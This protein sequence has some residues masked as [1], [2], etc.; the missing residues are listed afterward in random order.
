MY[1]GR[2][3][4]GY[5]GCLSTILPVI[6]IKRHLKEKLATYVLPCGFIFSSVGILV[7]FAVCIP[8]NIVYWRLL[9]LVPVL[10]MACIGFII[11]HRYPEESLG[12]PTVDS[13]SK[14]VEACELKTV[15]NESFV[16]AIDLEEN[17]IVIP[18]REVQFV[19]LFTCEYRN[20]VKLALLLTMGG[21]LSGVSFIV[22]YSSDIF[23]KLNISNPELFTFLLGFS[24]FAG[25]VV[26]VTY[27]SR[28][29]KR[30]IILAGIIG[31]ALALLTCVL[32]FMIESSFLVLLGFNGFMFAFAISLGGELGPYL[33]DFIP[34]CGLAMVGLPN[35]ILSCLI[36][37]F[38]IK[39]MSALG[40]IVTFTLLALI[41]S[42]IAIFF[43]RGS[44][45]T[46]G[47]SFEVI[48]REFQR[49]HFV[50]S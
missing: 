24:N 35:S 21:Q 19:E 46:E 23:K 50:N 22:Y 39:I 36:T 26:L 13:E 14:C 49:E 7:A 41:T 32:S 8:N 48:K 25:A 31:Q 15:H 1:L 42:R 44:V 28:Y 16:T 45:R 11:Y 20:Q 43:A 6:L 12:V 30:D 38:A 2:L 3:L 33:V 27:L 34:S 10:F 17:L 37:A 18:Q 47:K 40:N 4:A 5:F 29:S 9:F